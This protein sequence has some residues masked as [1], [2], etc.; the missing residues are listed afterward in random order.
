MPSAADFAWLIP[1]LPLVGALITGLGLISF[2]RTINRL[3]KP[4]A[5]LLISCIGAAAVI[6]Y[7]VLFEQLGGAPPVEHLF[8]WASAGDFSL[9]MGYVV[10]PLAA[11]MLALVTTVALLVMIYSHGYMAHDKGYVRF[12]TY[13]AIF[14]SSM[15]GLV[16]S[17]NL[18]EIYVFWELVGMASYLL[19]GFWYDRGESRWRFRTSARHSWA[20]LGHRKL[21]IPRHCRWIISSGQQ[22]SGA[23]MGSAR[24]LPVRVYGANGQVSPISS[25]CLAA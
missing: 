8:I 17:P 23:W 21:W 22:W 25:P 24:S 2:N 3:K 1:V 20:L 14:S 7:A 11:V 4:V 18:L 10:D 16:V 15:L 6:S 12:F 13:L 5:L 19:V 9:P